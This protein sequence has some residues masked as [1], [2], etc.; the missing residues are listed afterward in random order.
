MSPFFSI[1][2]EKVEKNF[3]KVAIVISVPFLQS[4]G[5]KMSQRIHRYLDMTPF[6]A[7]IDPFEAFFC[8]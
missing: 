6:S 7:N 1:L 3:Q 4:A 2:L 5:A 8:Q